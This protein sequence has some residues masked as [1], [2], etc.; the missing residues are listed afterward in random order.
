[1][2]SGGQSPRV[3]ITGT[4]GVGKTTQ[5][6]KMAASLKSRCVSAG[7]ILYGTK[8]V[9]HIE[10]LATYEIIDL[11][12]AKEYIHSLL[13]PGDVFETHVVDLS[14]DP[15]V[16]FVLRK[17]PDVLFREL[18]GRSWPLK[19]ILDNV[20]SEILDVVYVQ[21]RERWGRVYQV[22]VTHRDPE[23]THKTLLR[24]V[25]EGVCIDEEVDWLGYAEATG[26]LD[27]IESLSR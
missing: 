13:R 22:D 10:E 15:Q 21:A 14:P 24:C 16:V 20:W 17:A 9:R 23:E 27:F 25:E 3:F 4:P 7:E 6:I 1:M 12:G 19:K 18:A 26:F 11:E 2:T 8:Y 5:C